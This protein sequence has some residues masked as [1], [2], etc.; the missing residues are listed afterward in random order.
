MQL[1]DD[2]GRGASDSRILLT[3]DDFNVENSDKCWKD[4][5]EI[6]NGHSYESPLVGRFCGKL[7]EKV[8]NPPPREVESFT[9]SL[10][11]GFSSDGEQED[12]GFS[13]RLGS[14][15]SLRC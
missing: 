8:G 13:F 11:L 7:E 4:Y 3:F 12:T 2:T 5:L 6:Y 9:N 15:L 10:R 1:F 14:T